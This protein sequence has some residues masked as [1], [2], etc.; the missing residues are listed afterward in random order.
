[1]KVAV[2]GSSGL[3][4]T[5]LVPALKSAGH[6]V[7]RLVRREQR[8]AD[9]IEWDPTHDVIRPPGLAG[10][11]AVVNLSGAGIGDKRWTPERKREILDSRVGPTRLLAE[12]VAKLDPRPAAFLS[13]SAVGWYGDTG[14]VAKTEEDPAG[15][16]FLAEVVRQWEAAAQPAIDAGVRT[17]LLRSGVVLSK[18]G[19]ALARQLPFFKV[20]AGGRLGSGKQYLSWISIEDEVGAILHALTHEELNGP[21]N[22]VAPA[23]VTNAEF[24]SE[25]GHALHRPTLVPIPLFGPRALFGK[26][27]VEEMLLRGQRVLPA[28]L[29]A[30]GYQFQSADLGSALRKLLA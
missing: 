12:T 27:M 24:T 29:E 1:M 7:V 28:R 2:S 8:A 17:V 4:G 10:V 25:L 20:G 5:A 22:L 3:I 6:E 18:E 9:E 13:G 11:D 19:G 26:E 15:G 23:P 14:D 16:G 21:V 30:S